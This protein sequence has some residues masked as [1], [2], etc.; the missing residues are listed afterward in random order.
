MGPLNL[1]Q[2][3]CLARS[4]PILTK[5][6]SVELVIDG[7]VCGPGIAV[8]RTCCRGGNDHAKAWEDRD[9]PPGPHGALG[10]GA[11]RVEV[12][13]ITAIVETEPPP[14]SPRRRPA[15]LPTAGLSSI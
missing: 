6:D 9:H 4:E 15:K 5:A 11:V 13:L 10:A 7:R 1:T 3:K 12:A 2:N 8:W 14:R